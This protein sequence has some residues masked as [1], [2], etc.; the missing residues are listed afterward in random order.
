MHIAINQR[1]VD[2]KGVKLIQILSNSCQNCHEIIE[3][4]HYKLE[5]ITSN[6]VLSLFTIAYTL[7]NDIITYVYL[8]ACSK[9]GVSPHIRP[10]CSKFAPIVTNSFSNFLPLC[11]CCIDLIQTNFVIHIVIHLFGICMLLYY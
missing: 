4:H 1:Y 3:I 7:Y 11:R 6:I 8:Q 5:Y 10:K 9:R 2:M